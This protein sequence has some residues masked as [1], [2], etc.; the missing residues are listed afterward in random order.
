MSHT[1]ILPLRPPNPCQRYGHAT[2]LCRVV[3]PAC[4]VCAGNH[5]TKDYQCEVPKCK[6]GPVCVHGDIKCAA[7]GNLHNASDHTCPMRTKTSQ[8]FRRIKFKRA[9]N[10][11]NGCKIDYDTQPKDLNCSYSIVKLCKGQ[12]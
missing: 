8:A 5:L 11:T 2:E 10:T 4:D 3:N 7:F 9:S 1:A 6:A 12:R